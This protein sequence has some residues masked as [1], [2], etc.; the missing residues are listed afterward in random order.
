[1]DSAIAK[2]DFELTSHADAL[3]IPTRPKTPTRPSKN[4]AAQK[5]EK[6]ETVY[7]SANFVTVI[8]TTI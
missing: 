1:M 2:P 4:D 3:S 6:T 8:S 7:Q 5:H